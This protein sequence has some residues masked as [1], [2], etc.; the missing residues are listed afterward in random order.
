MTQTNRS[1]CHPELVGSFAVGMP[2]KTAFQAHPHI[3]L[4]D[5]GSYSYLH[6]SLRAWFTNEGLGVTIDR[7]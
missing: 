6:D 7:D 5:V 2:K 4:Y 3:S 1:R